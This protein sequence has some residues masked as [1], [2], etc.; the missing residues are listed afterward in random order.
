MFSKLINWSLQEYHSLPW[1][2]D[3]TLYKTLVSEIMLQQTTV[4]TVLNHFE[5][6]IQEYPDYQSVALAT[7]EQ[8]TISWKGLGYYRRARNLKKACEVIHFDH[9]GIM[10][11]DFESLIAIPGIGEY[12]ASAIRSIGHNLEALSIDANLERVLSRIFLIEKEKGIQLQREIKKQF[13]DNKIIKDRSLYNPRDLNEA[14]MD[15]GRNF[16]RANSVFCEICPM[17]LNCQAL[18]NQ[19]MLSIPI[20]TVISKKE[21]FDLDLLRIVCVEEHKVLVYKKS[22]DEWLSGQHEL[23]TFNLY[24]ND[25]KFNQYPHLNMSELYLLDSFKSAITKYKITNYVLNIAKKDLKNL[26]IDMN[27]YTWVDLKKTDSNLTTTSSKAIEF[28]N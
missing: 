7:D 26:E 28:I 24:C 11:K 6:F 14:L 18:K 4:G 16:C 8:L 5:R 20:K 9:N 19:K 1:R 13:K 27:K 2:V 17:S 25:S 21:S 10:P 15:L 23:P 22:K 12:T 3:R